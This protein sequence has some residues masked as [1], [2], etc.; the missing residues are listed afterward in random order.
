MEDFS[1][2][3]VSNLRKIIALRKLKQAKVGEYADISE[4]Q[5]SRVMNGQVQL[6]L[7]QLAN[8]A[9]GLKMTVVDIIT[10]PDVYVPKDKKEDDDTEVLLQFKLKKKKKDQVMKLVFGENDIEI[11]NK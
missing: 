11:L 7:N 3:I 5:F 2:L 10:F 8:I 1:S 9:S 4:S 6:S